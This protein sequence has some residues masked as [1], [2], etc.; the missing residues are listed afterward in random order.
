MHIRILVT[1][2]SCTYNH[3]ANGATCHSIGI[4]SYY[5]E[6]PAGYKGILCDECKYVS[7][8]CSTDTYRRNIYHT[9]TC[10]YNKIS[11]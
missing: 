2:H 4:Q 7:S 6:C 8:T 5:C 3:C 1:P 11:I 9:E 10:E